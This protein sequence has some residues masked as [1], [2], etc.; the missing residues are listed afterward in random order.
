MEV[1][2]IHELELICSNVVRLSVT[3]HPVSA[4][5]WQALADQSAR[6]L[7]LGN[8]LSTGEHAEFNAVFVLLIVAKGMDM[9]A[10]GQPFFFALALLGKLPEYSHRR[11]AKPHGL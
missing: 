6:L 8:R 11:R 2:N 4:K 9:M 1:E 7:F 3:V 5:P 10:P